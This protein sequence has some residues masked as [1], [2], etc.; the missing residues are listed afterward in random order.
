MSIPTL[1]SVHVDSALTNMSIAYIQKQTNFIAAQVF[2]LV[3][4]DSQSDV[5]FTFDRGDFNRDEAR[6]RAPG[7]ESAGGGFKITNDQTFRCPVTAFHF[8]IDRQKLKN[9][10]RIINLERSAVQFVTTKLLI[11]RELDWVNKYFKTGVWTAGELAGV[12]SSPTPGTS[13]LHWSDAASDPIGDISRAKG[14][15]LQNTGYEPNLLVLGFEVFEQLRNHPDIIERVKYVQ[16]IGANQ[17]VKVNTSALADLFDVE[18]VLVSKAIQ[19]TA[20]EGQTDAHSFIAGKHALL[21]YAAPEAAIE[22]PSAGYTF[23]WQRYIESQDPN[24]I[25]FDQFPMAH[26]KAQRVEGEMAIDQKL[27][28]SVL[29]YFF[30]TIVA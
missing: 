13:V 18:R 19:N 30:L 27:V 25:G 5:Y 7:T 3:P 26:L 15:I 11:R 6:E 14:A 16:N 29:G 21:C 1:Q 22:M 8:D 24:G 20:K 10:D 2:P 9:A 23:T 4:V 28:S 17:T 12:S